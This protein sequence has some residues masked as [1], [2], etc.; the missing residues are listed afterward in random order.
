MDCVKDSRCPICRNPYKYF[1]AIC[2][3]LHNLLRKSKPADYKRR[4][5]EVLIPQDGVRGEAS[6]ELSISDA[7]CA[8]CE[9]LLFRP[10]VLNCGHS[11]TSSFPQLLLP[12][13]P[14]CSTFPPCP[15]LGR[16]SLRCRVC[17]GVHPGESPQ[18]CLH[19]D[20]FLEKRFPDEYA[21]RRALVQARPPPVSSLS[22]P[23]CASQAEQPARL[24]RQEDSPPA[25]MEQLLRIHW[26]IGCDSCGMYP[27][28]GK[29]YKCTDCQEEM[30]F[31]FCEACYEARSNFPARFNQRHTPDHVFELIEF[32]MV[33]RRRVG[34]A[35]TAA[36]QAR[37]HRP[38][39]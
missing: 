37:H 9:Q 3:L 18:V 29:R 14:P 35:S 24:S 34:R 16:D 27:I 6:A 17:Q 26:G 19:L 28:F 10:T 5:E 39:L 8:G 36:R 33:K 11:E 30:G 20:A 23:N 1:P 22:L 32:C 7:L 38:V 21:S 13:R 2:P 12:S 4:E 25:S 15:S 31:D